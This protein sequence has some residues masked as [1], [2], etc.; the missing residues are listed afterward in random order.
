MGGWYRVWSAWAARW[1]RAGERVA[2]LRAATRQ[3]RFVGRLRGDEYESNGSE[4]G[5][6]RRAREAARAVGC[7]SRGNSG[8]F[9]RTSTAVSRRGYAHRRDRC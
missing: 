1:I 9:G 3:D 7:R 8:S 6:D 4:G 5:M 2:P